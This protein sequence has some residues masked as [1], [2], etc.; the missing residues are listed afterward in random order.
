MAPSCPLQAVLALSTPQNP[1]AG[2]FVRGGR[3]KAA[4]GALGAR[5]VTA[6]MSSGLA[7]E[8]RAPCCLYRCRVRYGV[9]TCCPFPRTVLISCA[10]SLRELTHPGKEFLS[11]DYA[12]IH[13]IAYLQ[14]FFLCV[15]AAAFGDATQQGLEMGGGGAGQRAPRPG[16]VFFKEIVALCLEEASPGVNL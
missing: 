11:V 16:G 5:S 9:C 13:Q 2:C 4:L 1:P 3:L 12:E 15:G 6:L 14:L 10:K 8:H 7:P